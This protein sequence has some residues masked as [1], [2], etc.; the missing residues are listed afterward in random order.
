MEKKEFKLIFT[1]KTEEAADAFEGVLPVDFV[2][3]VP[4][5]RCQKKVWKAEI[6]LDWGT[7]GTEEPMQADIF[8]HQCLSDL[9][10]NINRR[11]ECEAD[12]RGGSPAM[13][14]CVKEKEKR[15]GRES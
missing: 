8:C 9:L 4:C 15:E 2:A 6:L 13:E 10:E 12:F 11:S 5:N 1:K 3:P 7:D 14:R